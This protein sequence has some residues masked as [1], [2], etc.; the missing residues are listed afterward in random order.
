VAVFVRHSET[1]VLD[2][3]NLKEFPAMGLCGLVGFP[4]G[5]ES[6]G[7]VQQLLDVWL[8]IIVCSHGRVDEA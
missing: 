7:T 5:C 1:A 6:D 2:I 8:D 4:K 3:I